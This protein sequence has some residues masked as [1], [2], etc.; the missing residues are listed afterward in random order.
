MGSGINATVTGACHFLGSACPQTA[1]Q[2][3]SL[4][5]TA[6]ATERNWPVEA[7]PP[8]QSSSALGAACPSD[9]RRCDHFVAAGAASANHSAPSEEHSRTRAALEKAALLE[10]ASAGW[11]MSLSVFQHSRFHVVDGR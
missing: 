11:F 7:A 5:R 1:I 2:R 3:I 4:L 6:R 9:R 10:S 8:T